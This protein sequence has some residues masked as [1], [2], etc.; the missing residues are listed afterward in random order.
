MKINLS[1]VSVVVLGSSVLLAACNSSRSPQDEPLGTAEAAIKIVNTG[2]YNFHLEETVRF[3]PLQ[4]G[5]DPV[6]GRQLFGLAADMETEDKTD[7]L[8]EG[9]SVAANKT[10]VSNERTCFT[11]HRGLS[12]RLGLPVPPLSASVPLTD[13]LFTGLDGDAQGD[14]DGM[15]NLDQLGLIKYRPHR[16]DPRRP[17]SDPFK[18]VFFW[19]KSIIL[20]NVGLTNGLLNDA[21]LRAMFE[22]DRGAVFSHTQDEDDRFDDL[23]TVEDGADME[24]FQFAQF[25]D[26]VLAALRDPNDSMFQTLVEDPFYTVHVETHAQKRGKKVFEKYCMT[27]HNTPNVFNNVSNLEAFGNGE[28]LSNNPPFAPSV[29]RTFNVGVSERNKHNLRFTRDLGGGLF[30]PVVLPL[31]ENDGTTVSHT[32]NFDIGLAAVTARVDDI[33]RFKVPQLRGVKDNAPYFHD[34]SALTLEE[35]VDYFNSSYYN[36]SKDG[37]KFPIHLNANERADLIEFLLIL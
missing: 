29:A 36:N 11:C 35:V 20:L 21:R 25:T 16:F 3:T 30:A 24:A 14:P 5:A 34:N 7:A 2:S 23:F 33:G 26:P 19:R 22:T 27:C 8:F 10:I 18:Q 32:V 28:R 15:F 37:S 9:F 4:P 13:A 6:R 12:A 1:S 17:Q 31:V